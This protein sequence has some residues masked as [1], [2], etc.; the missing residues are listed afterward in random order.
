MKKKR[1]SLFAKLIS[2]FLGISFLLAMFALYAVNR[3]VTLGGYFDLAYVQAVVPLEDWSLFKLR[4]G[5]IQSLLNYHIA[6]Y[7]GGNIKKIEA[8]ISEKFRMADEILNR[9]GVPEISGEKVSEFEKKVQDPSLDYAGESDEMI[10]KYLRYSWHVITE[11]SKEIME[12]SRNYMKEDATQTLNSGAGFREF[13]MTDRLSSQMRDRAAKK[14]EEYRGKSLELRNQVRFRLIIGVI[15]F[16]VL[17]MTASFLLAQHIRTMVAK[18]VHMAEE[19]S[20]GALSLRLN[21][22]HTDEIGKLSDALDNMAE[23]LEAKAGIAESIADGDLTREVVLGSEKD[24]LGMA[25]Q[26]MTSNLRNLIGQVNRAAEQVTSGAEQIKN[27]GQSLSHN[28]ARQAAAIEQITSAMTEIGSQT[29]ANAENASHARVLAG[30]SRT[31]AEQ[32]SA[33]MKQMMSSMEVISQA[34]RSVAKII[35]VID[36][37][38]FQTNLLSLNA[39]VEAARAGRHGKGF[40]VVAG[41][42]RNLAARSAEAAKETADLIEGSVQKVEEGNKIA[43][44]TAAELN[45]I[46]DS[47]V[48]TAN[49]V[50]EIAMASNEQAQGIEQVNLGLS[51]VEQ[52]THQNIIS[53]EETAS[54]S[55]KFSDQAGELKNILGRFRLRDEGPEK[56]E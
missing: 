56:A 28:A 29:R 45:K 6:E 55:E 35:R 26:K 41:E 5:D 21:S 20:M 51:Q 11:L 27:S 4:A 10:M 30:E 33:E 53:A 36:E 9:L 40:A 49:L 19:V 14:V 17:A 42:V 31:M 32:G 23:G 44:K 37:I 39:A 34:S 47:T 2:T 43:V 22:G 52:V 3:L 38:A 48:K 46:L 15:L 1:L 24:I 13:Q 8:D 25:I 12:D 18:T 16:I 7:D 50:E 54:A